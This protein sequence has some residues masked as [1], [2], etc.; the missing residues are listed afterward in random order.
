MWITVQ[1]HNKYF[2]FKELMGPQRPLNSKYLQV[3]W[4]HIII[5]KLMH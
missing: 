5:V 2:E 3:E 1:C 4:L